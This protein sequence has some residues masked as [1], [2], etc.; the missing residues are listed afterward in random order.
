MRCCDSRERRWKSSVN[1]SISGD[2]IILSIN[3]LE[4]IKLY[5]STVLV[6]LLID[7]SIQT[8]LF[9]DYSGDAN[10][11][12]AIVHY[13]PHSNEMMPFCCNSTQSKGDDLW[14]LL[15]ISIFIMSTQFKYNVTSNKQLVSC[16]LAVLYEHRPFCYYGI[17]LFN[18]KFKSC[19][20]TKTN[21]LAFIQQQQQFSAY[22]SPTSL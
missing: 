12:A 14:L 11:V 3:P 22:M 8:T 5:S 16:Y 7:N 19:S 6:C 13:T 21:N 4:S 1:N 15:Y 18:L 2:V 17:C 9:N 20:A 10:K